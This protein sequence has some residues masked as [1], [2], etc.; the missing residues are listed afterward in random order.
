MKRI[1]VNSSNSVSASED[2][3]ICNYDWILGLKWSDGYTDY[4]ILN[5]DSEGKSGT[6]RC[7]WDSESDECDFQ[8]VD[9]ASTDDYKYILLDNSTLDILY[10]AD[11]INYDEKVPD[12][13]NE[14][15]SLADK[16][17]EGE[18]DE[19]YDYDYEEDDLK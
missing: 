11:A 18:G 2:D 19:D 17:F 9:D 1:I 13:C 5:V 7:S 10:L 6:I 4:E 3:N 12:G 14:M 15:T 8:I 16:L